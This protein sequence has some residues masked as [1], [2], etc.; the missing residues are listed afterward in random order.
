M[1]EFGQCKRKLKVS[2]LEKVCEKTFDLFE[3][4][5]NSTSKYVIRY[6]D[7]ELEEYID[8]SDPKEINSRR[9]VIVPIGEYI[10]CLLNL[11]SR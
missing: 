11:L 3:D 8:V 5:L 2:D 10:L 4:L 6:F 1:V 7:D 9:I